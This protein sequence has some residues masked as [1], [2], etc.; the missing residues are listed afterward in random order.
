[1]TADGVTATYTRVAGETV[2][3]GPYHITATLSPE[4]V[5]DNY[6]ITNTGAS[7]TNTPRPITVTADAKSKVYGDADP[8]LT[9]KI[10]S[11]SLAF[12]DAFAGSL[13][14]AIGENVGTYAITQGTLALSS[15]YT[16]SYMGANLT[17]TPRPIT[18]TPNSN[19]SKV[20]GY[21][22]PVL[23]FT[24]TSG[25][26]VSGDSFTGDLSRA[27][28][29]NVGTY[30][31]TQGTLTA[32]PNYQLSVTQGVNFTITTR[33]MTVTADAQTKIYGIP[34][35]VLTYKIT[36]GS[37]A[38]TDAFTG[39][40][41][42]TVGENV[43]MY[44]IQQGSLT[45]GSN[46]TLT[47]IGASLTI[48]QANSGAV[49][50]SSAAPA[51]F[52]QP[53]T[54]TAVVSDVSPGSTGTPTGSVQFYI[55][56]NPFG[57]A[58]SLSGGKASVSTSALSVATHNVYAVYAGDLNFIGSTAASISQV[59]NKA[60][61]S[62]TVTSSLPTSILNQAVTYK[63]AIA[64]VSPGA[65]TPTGTV[66]FYLDNT[67]GT[68]LGSGT[69][70]A[71]SVSITSSAVPVNS[72]AIIAVYSGDGSFLSSQGQTAQLVQYATG[73]MCAGD[74]GHAIRQPINVDGSSVFKM[75]STVP[76]KFAV[77][78]ANGVSIG[79]PGVVLTNGYGLLAAA[80]SP[81]ISVDENTYSTTPDTAF[82]FD[83]TG[84]QWIFN[85]GTKNN[86]TLNKTNTIY[87]FGIHLNDGSWIYFQY[88][89]K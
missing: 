47:Y 57:S 65:G 66:T 62:A 5:L 50:T 12:S 25:N 28:G 85:Q 4:G 77:C 31:I 83:P 23:T 13:T 27:V 43:G 82:R 16:L 11:G 21:A 38:F 86:G 8:A 76:T 68:V 80:S 35:P 34:D 75:G 58:V 70:S 72:H 18:V 7:F 54:F 20:Y 79:T 17:I 9:Y 64:V 78:D 52:G 45:A 41:I 89:L 3:D 88:G 73:G 87:Y 24:V 44:A 29:E 51:V 15:N 84:Q 36:S 81:N 63:A 49:V 48:N 37:L 69:V 74:V 26:L 1:M 71:G 56:G 40:L 55:D 42:R 59:V 2:L 33:P 46:Y 14:R 30:A 67:S 53:V 39:A 6:I 32:G 19:Q 10:T 22:D 61:T 60:A